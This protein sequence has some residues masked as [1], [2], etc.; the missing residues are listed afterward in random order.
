MPS[1]PRGLAGVTGLSVRQRDGKSFCVW[2][3]PRWAEEYRPQSVTIH[4]DWTDP[5]NYPLIR[6]ACDTQTFLVQEW[7]AAKAAPAQSDG[8][9]RSLSRI[10]QTHESS[11]F[12]G[13]QANTRRLYEYEL[14]LIESTIGAT[15]LAAI[16]AE[17]FTRW[18]KA[19]RGP[20]DEIRKAHGF[21]KRLRAIISFG[22]AAEV[23]G[24][25]RLHTIL[26]R[27]QFEQPARR[28]SV[29][30]Y[31][32]AAAIIEAAHAMGRP[33]I[34]LAQAIQ[35]ETGLRQT[36]VIGQWEGSRWHSGLVWQAIGTDM[37]L[38][39]RTSKTG[40]T[41]THDLSA[42]PLV[43]REIERFPRDRRIGPMIVNEE[44]GRP[45]LALVFS[46]NWRKVA[47][48]AGIP[49]T[50]WNRDSRAGAASESDDAGVGLN[51]VQRMLGHT[52]SK[53][54]ARYVRGV[55]PAKSRN[56]ATLRAAKRERKE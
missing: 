27:M 28:D 55:D 47:D 12:H 1:I 34:A 15:P 19:A 35:F 17:H 41:V 32:M 36:D 13:V 26:S 21:M 5:A 25:E 8:T 30:T 6:H 56:V 43:V 29:L 39:V 46:R 31:D 54:T 42:M 4:I 9:I 40:A 45:Y 3:A 18:Y 44:T 52:N 14:R 2:R 50:I 51:D 24:C 7:R 37:V 10:Y 53:M 38:S 49:S 20:D 48:A 16:R 33:S 11:P 23:E 22:V